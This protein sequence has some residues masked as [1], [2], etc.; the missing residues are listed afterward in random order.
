MCLYTGDGDRGE[1]NFQ[2]LKRT[3]EH[4]DLFWTDSERNP[5]LRKQT[6]ADSFLLD[7]FGSSVVKTLDEAESF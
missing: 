2:H 7:S 6:L 3:K 4:E 1:M 5:Q